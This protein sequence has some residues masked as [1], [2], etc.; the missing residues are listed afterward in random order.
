MFVLYVADVTD[1]PKNRRTETEK[2]TD[3]ETNT[4]SL[5]VNCPSTQWGKWNVAKIRLN[6][7]QRCEP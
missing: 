6:Q 5:G 4:E 1:L 7:I 3:R 2:Q